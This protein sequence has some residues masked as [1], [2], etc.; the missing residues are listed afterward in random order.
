MHHSK[1]DQA[2]QAEFFPH[3]CSSH[4]R[5]RSREEALNLGWVIRPAD[6]LSDFV[7][8]RNNEQ[9]GLPIHSSRFLLQ[10]V[11][12]RSPREASNI[13]ETKDRIHIVFQPGDRSRICQDHSSTSTQISVLKR[14]STDQ[15]DNHYLTA[16]HPCRH[17]IP[18][19]S[20]TTYKRLS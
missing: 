9:E 12:D 15:K 20:N 7:L 11:L 8:S 19:K 6:H 3:C 4:R 14:E 1:S 10:Q 5:W 17:S 2:R 18:S 13:G 16:A